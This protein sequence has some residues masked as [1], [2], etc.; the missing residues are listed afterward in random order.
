MYKLICEFVTSYNKY[1]HLMPVNSE[2]EEI[3]RIFNK[4]EYKTGTYRT[5]FVYDKIIK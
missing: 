1:K 3:I 4:K 2:V 5:D